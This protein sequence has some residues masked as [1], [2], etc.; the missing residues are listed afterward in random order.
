MGLCFLIGL[1]TAGAWEKEKPLRKPGVVVNLGEG[2]VDIEFQPRLT[3]S[4]A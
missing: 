4:S 1:R 3:S 2:F